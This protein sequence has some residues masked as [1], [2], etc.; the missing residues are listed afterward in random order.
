MESD[1][2]LKINFGGLLDPLPIFVYIGILEDFKQPCFC[3]S[4]FLVLV[5]ETICLEVGLLDQVI[6]I[7][8]VVRQVISKGLKRSYMGQQ[9]FFK[10]LVILRCGRIFRHQVPW[11][12]VMDGECIKKPKR[13]EKGLK[14][15][16]NRQG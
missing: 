16:D 5:N 9:L 6:G 4:S 11:W 1:N 12:V 14:A 7:F 13:E 15:M 3:I 8:L 10:D 2:I